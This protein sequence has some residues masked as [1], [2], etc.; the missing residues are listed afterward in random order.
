MKINY[1]PGYAKTYAYIIVKNIEGQ[2]YYHGASNNANT[3]NESALM[4]KAQ[5]INAVVLSTAS[6]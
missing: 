4:L 3:A 2:W 1:L 6:L 5:G